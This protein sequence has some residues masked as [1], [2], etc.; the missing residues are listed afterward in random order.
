MRYKSKPRY[1][2]DEFS[3]NFYI[4]LFEA[5]SFEINAIKKNNIFS[6]RRKH[7]KY[8]SMYMKINENK[9]LYTNIKENACAIRIRKYTKNQQK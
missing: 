3:G 2:Y 1:N 4:I 5:A 8:S 6:H 7:M 9:R